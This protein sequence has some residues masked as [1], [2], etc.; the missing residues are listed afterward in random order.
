MK[1]TFLLP[2]LL[3]RRYPISNFQNGGM[4]YEKGKNRRA[5]G[6]VILSRPQEK[7]L[8]GAIK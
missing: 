2:A 7:I 6:L 8:E 5:S 3:L 4:N 1:K